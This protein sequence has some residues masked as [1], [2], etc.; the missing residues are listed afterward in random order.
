MKFAEAYPNR[1]LKAADL[2]GREIDVTIDRAEQAEVGVDRDV[3]TLV[4]F[5]DLSKP[6]ILNKTNWLSISEI[7]KND[8]SD[9]WAG[10]VIR[11]VTTP[12]TFAGKTT[13][14]IRIRRA[15]A[16]APAAIPF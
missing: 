12:V 1:Y 10:F 2:A 8:D 7:A 9:S 3:K 5:N 6:L 16:T 4:Y 11:L 13:D 15:V 14:A